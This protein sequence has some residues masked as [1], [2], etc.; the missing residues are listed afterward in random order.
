MLEVYI[1]EGKQLIEQ[2]NQVLLQAEQNSIFTENDI[3][4]VFRVMHTIKSSSAMMGLEEMASMAHKLED[5]FAYLREGGS[6]VRETEPELF[7][8][9][10]AASDYIEKEL[11]CMTRED[12]AP[13]S[14]QEV[15]R[16]AAEYLAG[17]SREKA[18]GKVENEALSV[19]RGRAGTTVRIMFEPGCRM[20]NVRGFMLVR[21]IKSLCS[22][23]ETYPDEL[24]KSAEHALYIEKHG[25]L[26]Y[27][28]SAQKEA[29]LDILKKGLFVLSCEVLPEKAAEEE[30]ARPVEKPAPVMKNTDEVEF[31]N[32]RT[33]RLDRL[34]N[35]S[36]ELMIQMLTLDN[37]LAE[38]GQEE[39][40]E[41]V[42]YQIGRLISEVERTVMETRMVR[43]AVIVPKLQRIF[44]DITRDE[45]K[46]AKLVVNCADMEADKSI[47]DHLFE[48]L[49]HIIRN[50]VDHGIELPEEREKA[51]KPREGKVIFTVESAIGELL[52]SVRDDGRGIDEESVLEKAKDRNIIDGTE[53]L[54]SQEI[55][56]L[57]LKPGFSTK[58]EVT[59]YS[60]RGVGMDVVKNILEE[61]G[62]RLYIHS[63]KGEGS[64]FRLSV[65]LSLATIECA[66]FKIDEYRFS[67][68]A[69]HVYQFLNYEDNKKNIREVNGL[70]YILYDDVMVPLIDLRKIYHIGGS[71]PQGSLLIYVKLTE[72]EGCIL[73]DSMYEQK[74]IVVK[75][76]PALMGMEFRRSTGICGCS[77]MGSGKICAALDLELLINICEKERL[78]GSKR[79]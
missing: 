31:L 6:T 27:F 45:K 17:L 23:I 67:M 14:A 8:L 29:V 68:P 19:F 46:E 18:D 58:E 64:E 32:V 48:V 33:D 38:S 61:V 56:N 53:K 76:L 21:Q 44:R 16:T 35:L 24:E 13:G 72:R 20:E 7:D 49:M 77:I 63:K 78:S 39:I 66:R 11:E 54:D 1:L 9:L 47:V 79:E 50:A 10:Y 25:L 3:H 34:Q 15:E 2:L 60:G 57:I 30:K 52:V 70:E 59:E 26:I 75:Q 5:L 73:V 62:G 69:R 36:G 28:E 41:G 65:P 51:G 4:A 12:Y 42:A 22:N 37:A 71:T 40:R 74:R 55:C 43:V